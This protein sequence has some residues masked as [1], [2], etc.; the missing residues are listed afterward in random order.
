MSEFNR[1]DLLPVLKQ[2]QRE[3]NGLSAADLEE[4]SVRLDLPNNEVFGVTSFYSFLSL[5]PQGQYVI[6]IC[7]SLPCHL[8]E[9][10][11]IVQSV[12]RVLAI[13]PGELTKD[14][15]FGFEM[16]DCFGA[17]DLAPALMINDQVYG[18]L[19]PGKIERILKRFS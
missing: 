15:R 2:N 17:C 3:K 4:L 10:Q 5:K 7:R 16:T 14:G 9:Q 8:Q 13:G 12:R 6:R 11:M 1:R 18:H 19:T